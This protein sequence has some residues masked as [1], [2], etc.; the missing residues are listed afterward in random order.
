MIQRALYRDHRKALSSGNKLTLNL[1]LLYTGPY[2]YLK[3]NF[4]TDRTDLK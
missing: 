3:D 1:G 4:W 2:K